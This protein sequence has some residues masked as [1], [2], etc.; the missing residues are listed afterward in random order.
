MKRYLITF[1]ILFSSYSVGGRNLVTKSGIK[2]QVSL[3]QKI[4]QIMTKNSK[5][6]KLLIKNQLKLKEAD[7]VVLNLRLANL[8]FKE[9]DLMQGRISLE[10]V[11]ESPLAKNT[12]L[13]NELF[14]NLPQSEQLWFAPKL[15]LK[16]ILENRPKSSCPFF[17]LDSRKQRGELLNKL[18]LSNTLD[19][20]SLHKIWQEIFLI[21]PETIDKKDLS[22]TEEFSTWENTLSAEDLVKRLQNLMLFGKNQEAKAS[23]E[24]ALKREWEPIERCA[25]DYENAKIERRMRRYKEARKQFTELSLKCDGE[26]KQKSRYMDLQLAAMASDD[27]CYD[28]IDLFVSDYPTHG[29]S[30]DVL[31]FKTM[32][33]LEHGEKEQALNTLDYLIKLFPTGDMIEKALFMRALLLAEMGKSDQ[34][35]E[36]LK[37][38]KDISSPESLA[39]AQA[40]YWIARLN[41]FS[42]LKSLKSSKK[43][44]NPAKKELLNLVETEDP[45]VYSWLAYL[46]LGELKIKPKFL[47]T[48]KSLS[49]T[50]KEITN[51]NIKYIEQLVQQGF[52]REALMLLNEEKLSPSEVGDIGAMAELYIKIGQKEAGHQKLIRCDQKIAGTLRKYWRARYNELAWPKPYQV[53]VNEASKRAKVPK[54]IIWAIMHRESGFLPNARSWA[55]A[56]GLMQ[57]MMS[58]ANEHAKVLGIK[59]LKPEDL[60][61]PNLNLLLGSYAFNKYWQRF[62]NIA[63]ALSAYNAGPNAAKKWLSAYEGQPLDI[64]LEKIPFKETKAYV[65][66]VLG[67][68][69]SYAKSEGLASLPS[70]DLYLPQPKS[71]N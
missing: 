40:Q 38:L 66:N 43:N 46:L 47:K 61:N 57:L 18:A 9:G 62:G 44:I 1:I 67:A 33:Q 17:E 10:A 28:N 4:D 5:Q 59:E 26:I 51:K 50:K 56:R 16:G 70:L 27:K 49:I 53:Q 23:Y 3:G 71:L 48:K 42:D 13:M 31:I 58:T 6:A 35:L 69:F 21:L 32:I 8:A 14:N 12:A 2:S 65:E 11:L 55:Q 60:F 34:A 45:T 36:V 22:V 63:V 15:A 54:Q 24:F 52:Y 68:T 20:N 29:F 64:F 37:K 7:H 19:L 30:D 39:H 41:I 25:L